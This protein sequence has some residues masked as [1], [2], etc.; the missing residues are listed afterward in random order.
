VKTSST[1]PALTLVLGGQ[2]SG[3][4]AH[5]EALI[6]KADAVY[7]ATCEILDGTMA[8]RIA[9]HQKRRGD[10]WITVEEPA[11][12]AAA[13]VENDTAGRPILVDSLGMWISNLLGAGADPEAEISALASALKKLTCPVVMVSE[14]TGLGIIPDNP[15]ARDF[16]DALGLA[17]QVIADQA[18]RV[19]LI[20]AGQALTLKG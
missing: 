18:E 2:R 19:V 9:R 10:H 5:G 14:E 15:L 11:N 13:L 4:S 12:L 17:N 16:I 6:G 8:D 3:K 7:L 20:V 1:L